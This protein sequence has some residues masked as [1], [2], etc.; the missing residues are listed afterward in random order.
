MKNSKK[1]FT[2]KLDE[3]FE[4]KSS[5]ILNIY[6]TAGYPQLNSTTEIMLELQAAGADI[7]EIGI[8]YSDPIAD[9]PII[10]NSNQQAIQN[11][12]NL[13]ILFE[14]L[15]KVKSQVKIPIVLMGYLNSAL[16]FGFKEFC[17]EASESGVSGLIFPDMPFYEFE[18][19]FSQIIHEN[20]LHFIFLITPETSEKRMKKADK[21]S[22]GF[23]YAVS[24]STITGTASIGDNRE[25]YFEKI[26]SSGFRNPVL[27]GFG[28]KDQESFKQACTYANG[29]IIG[30]AFIKS[31]GESPDYGQ[32]PAEFVNSILQ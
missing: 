16:Q 24:S 32:T 2:N 11:G 4:K 20:G 18:N 22:S 13:G 9:G 7:L 26:A 27:I 15:K 30:S 21:L 12:M 8:P 1:K 31:L 25:S 3:V 14:Q 19:H 17:R 28:I 23:L 10:Q 5:G 6:L 29:A